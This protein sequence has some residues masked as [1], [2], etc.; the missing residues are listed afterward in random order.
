MLNNINERVS[1]RHVLFGNNSKV[2]DK[3]PRQCGVPF[4]LPAALLIGR[5]SESGFLARAHGRHAAR[6]VTGR[7]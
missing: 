4:I 3:L 5:V 2:I 1:V 6:R 7:G